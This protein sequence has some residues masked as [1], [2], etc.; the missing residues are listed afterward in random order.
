[1]RDWFIKQNTY[2][3]RFR[4]SGRHFSLSSVD[5]YDMGAG[6]IVGVVIHACQSHSTHWKYAQSEGTCTISAAHESQTADV[7]LEV[8][9]RARVKS[10]DLARGYWWYVCIDDDDHRHLEPRGTRLRQELDRAWC[11]V[12]TEIRM[13]LIGKPLDPI[14]ARCGRNTLRNI[15]L[16]SPLDGIFAFRRTEVAVRWPKAEQDMG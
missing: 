9:G 3:L 5:H 2:V 6:G 12:R 14:N 8:I 15:A 7:R 1:M 13:A 16:I 4:K 11:C 10:I